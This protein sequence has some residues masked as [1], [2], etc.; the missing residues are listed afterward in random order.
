MLTFWLSALLL[1][2]VSLIIILPAFWGRYRRNLSVPEEQNIDVAKERLVE[3]KLQLDEKLIEQD[4]YD[5]QKKE[6][7]KSLA[8]DIDKSP[9]AEQQIIGDKKILHVLSIVFFIPVVTF[10][11][12]FVLGSPEVLFKDNALAIKPAQTQQQG[13][14][15]QPPHSIEEMLATLAQKLKENP[16]NI[17]G[18]MMLGRSYMSLDR[19]AEAAQ[20]FEKITTRFGEQASILLAEADALAMMQ[21]GSMIGKPARLVK[22]ALMLEP[23]NITGLWLAGLASQEGGDDKQAIVYWKQAESSPKLDT[24]SKQKLQQLIIGAEQ[25]AGIKSSEAEVPVTTKQSAGKSIKV[26]VDIAEQLRQKTK[27]SDVVFI[28]ARAKTGPRMPLAIVR[29]QVAELPVEVVLSDEQAMMPNMALSNFDEVVVS[30]RVSFSGQA[31][32]QG[33]DLSADTVIVSTS[34]I[35]TV[36][37]K[38]VNVVP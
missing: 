9:A 35:S 14:Q 2:A 11:L 12:Y 20:V 32:P 27:P 4:Q 17:K 36:S 16:D 7:E 15:Q 3:L 37:I 1:I 30:A 26:K 18:W 24:T 10:V 29:K 25:R 22:K 19:F 31:I 23:N 13:Q 33:G 5:L 21:S 8:I 34:S 28:F 38:I 6:L